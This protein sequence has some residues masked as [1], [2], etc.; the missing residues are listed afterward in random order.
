MSFRKRRLNQ[1]LSESRLL[2]TLSRIREFVVSTVGNKTDLRMLT[3][4]GCLSFHNSHLSFRNVF[5]GSKAPVGNTFLC[6][7]HP[8]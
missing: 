7:K 1:G 5:D 2:S 4:P 8:A 6:S 3:F